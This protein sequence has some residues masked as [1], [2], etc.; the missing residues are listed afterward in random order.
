MKLLRI[1][2]IL[3]FL[4]S[5][6]SFTT[7]RFYVKNQI[8]TIGPEISLPGESIT[9]SVKDST[10]KL[11]EGVAAFDQMDKDVTKSIII[12]NI[13]DF[14]ISGT[15]M[16]TYAAFDGKYNVTTQERE[17][18]YSDYEPIR[19]KLSKPLSFEV[20]ENNEIL[21]SLSASDSLDGDITDKISFNIPE[22]SF[23]EIQGSYMVKFQV[24]NSAGETA[25]L[26]AEVEFHNPDYGNQEKI[27]ELILTEYLIYQKTGDNVNPRSYLN[28]IIIGNQEY[29]LTYNLGNS[30]TSNQI[31]IN[32]VTYESNLDMKN[33]GVYA[34]NYSYT[35]EDG[36]TGT[37]RL[38]VVVEE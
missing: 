37:T 36:Y 7:Y 3:I 38:L 11:L 8:D 22:Y 12:E 21:N 9:I 32:K 23:G 31:D 13:S 15:R 24:T 29:S 19:F 33:P 20:G 10:E 34:I 35:S 30:I 26:P 18:V 17:L 4:L 2:G 5:T 16:I 28:K 14:N 25:L 1:A 27:P 6:I